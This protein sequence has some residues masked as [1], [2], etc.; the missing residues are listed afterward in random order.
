MPE[1]STTQPG[2]AVFLS[3]AREDVEQARRIADALRAFGI[4][5]WFDQAEL[6]GG[7]A[8]DQK[9]RRQIRECA[10]F[11]PLISARTQA[12]GEGYFRREWNMG[13]ERTKDM[14]HG[15]P[16]IVPVVVDDTPADEAMVPEEFLRYQW[17]QLRH[18]VPSSQFV[19]QVKGL[20]EAPKK[21]AGSRASAPPAKAAAAAPAPAGHR[22]HAPL[23][24]L[25]CFAVLVAGVVAYLLLRP[26]RSPEEVARLVAAATT[27]ASQATAAAEKA[28]AG[29]ESAPPPTAAPAVSDKSVAVL[30]FENMSEDK[31]TN[32]F[33]AD[34]IHEDILTNLALVKGL[35]VVSRT[36]VMQY[37]G[38]TKPIREIAKELGVA[39][40]LE[41]SVR[42][43]GNK[44]R[45]TG[46]LIRAATDEHIWAKS[47][48]RDITD[49]FAIQGE[50]SQ[51]I[52]GALS[53]AISPE[54][55]ALLERRPTDS[56]EAYDLYLKARKMR[57]DLGSLAVIEPLLRSAVALDPKFAAAW[58]ELGSYQA[59]VFFDDEDHTDLRLAKAKEAI[60]TAN[61]VAPDDPAVIEDTGDYYYYGY[62][63]YARAAEQYLRLAQLRPNDPVMYYSLALIHRRQ[64]HWADSLVNF[65]RAMELDPADLHHGQ[66]FMQFLFNTRHFDEGLALG[67]RLVQASPEKVLP[68]I[69]VGI[70]GF[71]R[72]GSAD[73][74]QSALSR[75][76]DPADSEILAWSLKISAR[77]RGDLAEAAR[78][79]RE[80]PY[81]EGLGYTRWQ[82]DVDAAQ[83]LLEAGD[84]DAARARADSAL[85]AMTA[86]LAS[87]PSNASLWANLAVARAIK[88]EKDE[89]IR[90]SEKAMELVPESRD[91]IDGPT[92]AG[93]HASVLA[94]LGEK[95]RALAEIARL[96]KVP[97]S[98]VNVHTARDGIWFGNC[99][100][101][102]RGD[103]RFEALLNDPANNQ[104]Q[105]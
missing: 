31:D 24:I 20:L 80:R 61:R 36:S 101:A 85:A 59:F 1:S 16:F 48:D 62:R 90:C 69:F 100:R 8:W 17:T 12:R 57:N 98:G 92:Y 38:A 3:Y 86:E 83:V 9:I 84:R 76:F 78:L 79:D 43:A 50:L 28:D 68:S 91:A 105:F 55:K 18:G 49:I 44:V 15:V 89:A 26:R 67:R 60:E 70:C 39:Y 64:G 52:A 7:D 102:L 21:A 97:F 94:Q 4:E 30:P 23:V 29:R 47:Y 2:P 10:L 81:V 53:A 77:A 99:F 88:G 34:G 71:L 11:M 73:E 19:E 25:G 14:A 45:V 104:P 58:A 93:I 46:Q 42:R 103:P 72:D 65:R 33:F 54:E 87:Q 56:T 51:A 6:R 35:R 40:I 37:R 66:E 5:V 41:G 27:I 22:S 32:A 95:D 75:K 13:V 63:D 82:Q 74:L 96:L